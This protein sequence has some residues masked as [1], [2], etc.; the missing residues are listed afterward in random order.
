MSAL[1]DIRGQIPEFAKDIKLNLQTVLQQGSLSPEQRWGVAVA[2]AAASRHR[3]LRL[4]IVSDASAA[5]GEAVVE[6]GLAAA[7]LMG[8]NNVYY[9]FRHMIGKPS[10][11]DKPARLRMNRL[12]KP[13]TNKLDFELFSL[14]VSAING[15]ETCV[16][17]HEKVVVDGG[18]SEDHVHDA[19]RLAA[20]IQAAAIALE[21]VDGRSIEGA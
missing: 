5:V 14:A 13:A 6:D 1:E 2:A 12:V 10:Y 3:A 20:T 16:R 21:A 7:A 8:M 18:L 19:V 4:A 17:A 15:C 11:G 9:R